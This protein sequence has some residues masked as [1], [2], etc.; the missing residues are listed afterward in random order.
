MPPVDF[1]WTTSN[2]ITIFAREWKSSFQTRAVI[3]IVHG[4]GEHSLR[5]DFTARHFNNHGYAVIA[6]DLQGHGKSGGNRGYATFHQSYIEID[7]AIR[8]AKNRY[9]NTP[10]FLYGHS[11]GASLVL[12]YAAQ[13]K[14]MI[15]GL[16]AS[17]P[18]IRTATPITPFKLA[19]GKSASY[20]LPALALG[21]DL[22]RSGLSR[23]PGIVNAYIEDPLVH[24][25]VTSRLGMDLVDLGFFLLQ[26]APEFTMPCLLMQ[27]TADR[28]VDPTATFEF[29]SKAPSSTTV[30]K[31]EGFYHELHNEP[32]KDEVL[33]YV[34]D[35]ID[36][37]I[38]G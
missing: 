25:R 33:K 26:H 35:W 11:L 17:A 29:A 37:R 31:W 7:R 2:N 30:K 6:F 5:Y 12:I 32:E 1:S 38:H 27:G 21:N 16:I 19:V 18:C 23:D 36:H 4:L 22:D 9:P 24:D 28:I 20:V 15:N 13:R 10:V 8:E 34:E 3:I 14:P